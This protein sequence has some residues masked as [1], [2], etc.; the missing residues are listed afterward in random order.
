MDLTQTSFLLGI[1]A[2]AALVI[3]Y[4]LKD[5]AR[6]PVRIHGNISKDDRR[7]LRLAVTVSATEVTL[8]QLALKT[9]AT[10]LVQYMAKRIVDDCTQVNR[11]LASLAWRYRVNVSAEPGPEAQRKAKHLRALRGSAFDQAYDAVILEDHL[12]AIVLFASAARST[13]AEI[14]DLAEATLPTLDLHLKMAEELDPR[15][16]TSPAP[17]LPPM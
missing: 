16:G 17:P 9:S 12:K 10:A 6:H 3:Y 8:S 13:N 14:R 15:A 5:S 4:Q 11:R 1:L 7:F 2:L